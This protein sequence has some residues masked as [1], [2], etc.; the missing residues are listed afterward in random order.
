MFFFPKTTN[1]ENLT[2]PEKE[3]VV[4]CSKSNL[5]ILFYLETVLY[6]IFPQKISQNFKHCVIGLLS[7]SVIIRYKIDKL[8]CCQCMLV[9]LTKT[10]V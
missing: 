6:E 2:E 8:L 3:T 9:F 5:S 1:T 4:I 7:S 10:L